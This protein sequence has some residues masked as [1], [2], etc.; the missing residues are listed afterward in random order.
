MVDLEAETALWQTFAR[1]AVKLWLD[2]TKALVFAARG[3]KM[4]AEQLRPYQ[5]RADLTCMTAAA[6]LL[7]VGGSIEIDGVVYEG[8]THG[9]G[10]AA[11][12]ARKGGGA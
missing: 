7:V 1:D 2:A 4:N 8:E 12:R 5:E 11:V 10:S 3:P 6:A 9:P